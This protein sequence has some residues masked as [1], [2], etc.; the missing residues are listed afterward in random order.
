MRGRAAERGVAE[1]KGGRENK[2]LTLRP[3]VIH[4]ESGE[5]STPR[6]PQTRSG[7]WL[8][9]QRVSPDASVKSNAIGDGRPESKVESR[10]IGESTLLSVPEGH[11]PGAAL[12]LPP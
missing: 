10:A 12:R 4:E 11:C 9:W 8:P 7:E 6:Q 1:R 3:P 5:R 2:G